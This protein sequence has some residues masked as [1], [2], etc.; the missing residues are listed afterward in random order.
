MTS[1]MWSQLIIGIESLY[2]LGM[3][4][5]GMELTLSL[6]IIDF[7]P[8]EIYSLQKMMLWNHHLF[9]DQL[10]CIFYNRIKWKEVVR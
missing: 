2:F 9:S 3:K 6:E 7:K 4:L 8:K 1:Q 10:Y 5:D